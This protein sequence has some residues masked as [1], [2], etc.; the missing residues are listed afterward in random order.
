MWEDLGRDGGWSCSDFTTID[1]IYMKTYANL[2]QQ[3]R[4]ITCSCHGT[5]PQIQGK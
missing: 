1:M 4:Q 2:G 3:D 5:A